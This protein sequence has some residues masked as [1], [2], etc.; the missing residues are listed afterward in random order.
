MQLRKV[1][2]I[3]ETKIDENITA[4][5]GNN[6]ILAVLLQNRG[7]DTKEKIKRFLNPLKNP[8]CSPFVFSDMEKTLQRIKSAV[9][10]SENITVYGDFDADGITSTAVLYLTLKQI[11]AKVDYYL[12]DRTCE[13][14]GLNTKALVN[15][16]AKRKSKLIITVDC[17]ISNITEVNFA[18][19]FKADVIIT[20]HHESGE[21]LPE[22]YAIINPKAQNSIKSDVPIDEIESLNRLSGA[23]IALKLACAL[24]EMF[25]KKEFVNEILPISAIG[26]VGDVVELIGENRSIVEMGLELLRAGK[27]KGIQKLLQTA[28]LKDIT[29][30]TS[31]NIAFT[32]VPRINAAGRLENPYTALNLFISDDENV[33]DEAVKTLN[34]LNSLRQELCEETFNQAKNLYEADKISNKRSIVL[35]NDNWHIGIIGIVASK[36]VETYNKPVFLMTRDPN[37]SNIIRCSVRSIS[38]VDVYSILSQH[39]EFFEGFGGHKSAA[40]FSFDENKIK[41]E[42]FKSALNKTIEEFTQ[43]VD[44]NTSAITADMVLEPEDLTIENIEIINRLQPFGEGNPA[45]LFVMNDL[46]VK[47]YKFMGQNSNHLKLFLTKQNS[48]ILECVKWSTS[49]FKLPVNSKLDILFSPSVNHF[50]G[51][52]NI[53]LIL[54]DIR[55]DLLKSDDLTVKILDH[56]N[57]KNILMQVLDFLGSTKK[58]TGIFLENTLLKKELNLPQSVSDKLFT[59]DNI[60]SDT[61]QIMFFDCP[62]NYEEFSKIINDTNAQIVHLMNFNISDINTD[63]FIT[64]LSGM[65]KYALANLNGKFDI[66][67]ASNALSVDMQTL[68]CALELLEN[69]SMTQLEKTNEKEYKVIALHPVEI[70]KIKNDDLYL[71]LEE[72]ISEINEFRKF[73]LT[74][75]TEEIKE[76]ILSR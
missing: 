68:D 47:E 6:R 57:K 61:Q 43:D 48:S 55:S 52:D 67:R 42:T 4:E 23:G 76:A 39:K 27:N 45:P 34:E 16:I 41:F 38:G 31:E 5:C 62:K 44:F 73:Y 64:K 32:V 25:D 70:S 13:S 21:V 7:I 30:L 74:S 58:T 33:I 24:L 14:H 37:S 53:Q 8:L 22:A 20:D 15:I 56:R 40:G 65:L 26:T 12:P 54:S 11:G 1:W 35:L 71:E 69:C 50:N 29:K 36:L 3:R 9:E 59:A 17:G 46:F 10:N 66:M 49:E 51:E 75:S 60:P 18:K 72:R 28:G 2:K 63:S 19:G